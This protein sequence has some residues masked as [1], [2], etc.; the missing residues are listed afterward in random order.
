MGRRQCP[1]VSAT[2][3]VPDWKWLS[4]VIPEKTGPASAHQQVLDRVV[5]ALLEQARSPVHLVRAPWP[6]S[7][8]DPGIGDD[9][10][11]ALLADDWA[12]S[13]MRAN[14]LKKLIE[15]QVVARK[16]QYSA[17]HSGGRDVGIQVDGDVVGRLLLDLDDDTVPA[18]SAPITLVDI[19]VHPERQRQGIGGEVLTRVARHGG[20]DG[21]FGRAVGAVRH[22]G[23]A[24]VPGH[25]IRRHRRRCA[26]PATG[27]EGLSLVCA[28]QNA[29]RPG[30]IDAGPV[31]AEAEGFEPPR[32]LTPGRFQ[33]GFLRPLGHASASECNGRRRRPPGTGSAQHPWAR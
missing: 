24:V 27:M 6:L 31:L 5:D 17:E 7:S 23:A 4:I 22:T 32:L 12:D 25:G 18:E 33:G 15:V 20:R 28:H 2:S 26:V 14:Q 13:G 11:R 8:D 30:A 10:H 21:P 29:A 19:A 9:V 3:P 1:R 16:R